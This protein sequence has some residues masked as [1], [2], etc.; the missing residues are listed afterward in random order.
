MLNST[1]LLCACGKAKPQ[2]AWRTSQRKDP[3]S[4]NDNL[5]WVPG[6]RLCD[7]CDDNVCARS[8]DFAEED[9]G[10]VQVLRADPPKRLTCEPLS[11][12]A[13]LA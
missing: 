7:G 1:Q 3:A 5:E 11:K 2:R 6:N 12:S 13:L 9:D 4:R 8:V 10:D